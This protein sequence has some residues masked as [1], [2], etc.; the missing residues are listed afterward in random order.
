MAAY[1]WLPRLQELHHQS[2]E[3]SFK[4]KLPSFIPLKA[5]IGELGMT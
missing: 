2:E 3:Q 5:L 1:L 4:K